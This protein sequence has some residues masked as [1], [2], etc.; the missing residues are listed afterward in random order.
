M[1]FLDFFSPSYWGLTPQIY[2]DWWFYLLSG[3]FSGFIP[4]LTAATSLILCF[5]TV[6]TRKLSPAFA[7]LMFIVAVLMT[8]LVPFLVLLMEG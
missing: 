2:E 7:V 4:R 6:V 5:F 1:S 8:Y 3:V